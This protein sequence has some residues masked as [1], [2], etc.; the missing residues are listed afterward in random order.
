MTVVFSDDFNRANEALDASANWSEVAGTTDVTS[1]QM[2]TQS[3][4]VATTAS[5]FTAITEMQVTVTMVGATSDGGPIARKNTTAAVQTFYEL[6]VYAS[7]S[8]LYRYIAGVA[9]LIDNDAATLAAGAV[10]VLKTE[11]TGATVTFTCSYNAIARLVGITDT[12]A[13]RIVAAGYAGVHNYVGTDEWDNF[14]VDDLAGGATLRRYTL[15]T[16]GVG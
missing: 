6:D 16:L 15:T 12:N 13:A 1:N 4:L 3:A 10:M 14:S 11:G 8:D 7:N 5:A 9:T 2:V